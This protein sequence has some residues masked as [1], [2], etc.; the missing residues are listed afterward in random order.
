MEAPKSTPNFSPYFSVSRLKPTVVEGHFF[1][2]YTHP[3]ARELMCELVSR[4]K[5]C[6][7][8][9]GLF[10]LQGNQKARVQL[11][12][13]SRVY[14]PAEVDIKANLMRSHWMKRPVN[15]TLLISVLTCCATVLQRVQYTHIHVY[16]FI[17]QEYS[18]YIHMQLNI[19]IWIF[20]FCAHAKRF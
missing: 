18:L 6:S 8:V 14:G 3:S 5:G 16:V 11:S 1:F 2:L 7:G 19:S 20:S 9:K 15:V 10:C 12:N 13:S 17:G 4:L